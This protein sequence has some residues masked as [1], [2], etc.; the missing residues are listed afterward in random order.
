METLMFTGLG[1]LSINDDAMFS[2]PS[3]ALFRFNPFVTLP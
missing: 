3:E 2:E 1:L